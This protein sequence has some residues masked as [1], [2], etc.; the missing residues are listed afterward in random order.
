MTIE[1]YKKEQAILN[2]SRNNHLKDIVSK[3]K[4]I[5][6]EL[7]ILGVKDCGNSINNMLTKI[8]NVLNNEAEEV[9]RD[10]TTNLI[11]K[12]KDL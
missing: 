6:D 1:E 9:V 4:T 2:E 5:S 11:N 12:P 3:L 10:L 8:H 7:K